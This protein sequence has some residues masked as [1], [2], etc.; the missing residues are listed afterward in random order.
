MP[1]MLLMQVIWGENVS[2]DSGLRIVDRVQSHCQSRQWYVRNKRH[3][4]SIEGLTYAALG[5]VGHALGRDNGRG[6]G[7]E[8]SRV[9]HGSGGFCVVV[10]EERSID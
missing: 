2:A 4:L 8:G 3:G 6:G 9:L 5:E 1:S 7:D 10:G